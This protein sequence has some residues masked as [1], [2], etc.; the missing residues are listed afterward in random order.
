MKTNGNV[1]ILGRSYISS[2]ILMLG[3]G[4]GTRVNE[5]EQYIKANRPNNFLIF[6]MDGQGLSRIKEELKSNGY[7]IYD[8]VIKTAAKDIFD[9]LNDRGILADLVTKTYAPFPNSGKDRSKIY[10]ASGILKAAFKKSF[11]L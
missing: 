10:V 8:V 9:T 6:D 11:F 5:M 3:Q 1:T 7:V 4:K 2:N